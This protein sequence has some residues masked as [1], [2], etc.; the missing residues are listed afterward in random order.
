MLFLISEALAD[1]KSEQSSGL[2]PFLPLIIFIGILYFLLIRPQ[3]KKQKQHQSLISSLKKADKVITSSGIIATVS[4]ILNDQEIV[5]EIADGVH[6]KFVKSA[7]ATVFNGEN[8]S[9]SDT[10]KKQILEKDDEK[11]LDSSE[12][13]TKALGGA[14]KKTGKKPD[15]KNA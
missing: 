2:M 4:K 7:I 8:R 6:C 13:Q 11:K 14:S 5:L 9:V 3:Q 10:K 1:G 15:K 12:K